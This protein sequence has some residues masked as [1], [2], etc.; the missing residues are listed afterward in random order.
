MRRLLLT[1]SL[2]LGTGAHSTTFHVPTDKPTI[3]D[4]I[5][6]CTVGD[7]V[8]VAPGIYTGAG[9]RNLDFGGID[10]VLVSEDGAETTIIDCDGSGENP[11]RG[12]DFHSGE[13]A[14]AVVD[15]FTITRGY[16][17]AEWPYGGGGISCAGGSPLLKNC[18]I[19][20]NWS[21]N[22]GGG[23]SCHNSS[24]TLRSCTIVD[25]KAFWEGG[26]V[27]CE[28]SSPLLM[29][30]TIVANTVNSV[31]GGI[32]CFG[33]SP[34][35]IR[36]TI[37]DNTAHQFGGG[38]YCT[39]DARTS[40]TNCTIAN[41][42]AA[43]AGGGVYCFDAASP[44][45]TNCIVW[46]DTP[47]EVF[48]DPIFPGYPALT[49]CDVEGGHAGV[50]NIDVEPHF[51]GIGDYRLQARSCGH[52]QDSRCIDAGDPRIED[53]ILD[54][55]HGLGSILSDLGAWGGGNPVSIRSPSPRGMSGPTAQ[56]SPAF[57]NPFNPHTTIPFE[58]AERSQV[59]LLVYDITGALVRI[60][61]ND[62][63]QAGSHAATWDGT[64]QAGQA[65]ATGVYIVRLQAGGVSETRR[66]V[67]VK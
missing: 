38:V 37:T 60:L 65:V 6:A 39:T 12:L 13:T 43:R 49:F 59:Q 44:R 24:P 29:N 20:G 23:V 16:A 66:I 3:Q 10:L 22:E 14:D 64:N 9:N 54:C 53:T 48:S 11:A 41:N 55:D 34:T 19:A 4:G 27:R 61:E 31:G 50:G 40:L 62:T 63:R 47:D 36:C 25:N 26:G 42:L 2:A 5:D 21:D 52:P 56:L 30:C 28:S 57:P 67:L 58:L 51:R 1:I 18:K 7:T 33:S 46:G 45:L 15:G 8:L 17:S 32:Y 35:L